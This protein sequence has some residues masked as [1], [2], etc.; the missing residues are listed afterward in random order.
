MW[1]DGCQS[2]V[3]T[4]RAKG[5]ERRSLTVGMMPRPFGT[6]KEPFWMSINS[7]I[8]TIWGYAHRWAEILLNVN[9]DQGRSECV[10][11]H[12]AML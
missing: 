5:S 3:A 11:R 10:R 6:A 8:E 1:E 7:C 2:F 4:L 9:H 12:G